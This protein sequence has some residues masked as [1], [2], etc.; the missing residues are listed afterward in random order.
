MLSPRPRASRKLALALLTALPWLAALAPAPA[1]A[2]GRVAVVDVQQAVMAT[3]DGIRAQATLKKYFDKRQ[4]D[5]DSLQEEMQ[6]AREDIERQQR[7]LSR[8]AIARR[9]EDWQRRMIELQTRYVDYNKELQKK[10][11]ELTGPIIKKLLGIVARL[12]KKNGYDLILD[13]SATAYARPDLELTEQVIQMYN[14]GEAGDAPAEGGGDK[15]GGGD[16]PK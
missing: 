7:I 6:K 5:L 12:A 4:K 10:Q 1:H 13:R 3:E 11:S 8:E 15:A 16:A 14:S 9:M 2:E